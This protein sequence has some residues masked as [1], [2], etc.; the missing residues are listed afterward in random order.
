MDFVASCK[1]AGSIPYTQPGLKTVLLASTAL[2][3]HNT[4]ATVT[5]LTALN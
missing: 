4:C 1:T 2:S 5:N 3:Y